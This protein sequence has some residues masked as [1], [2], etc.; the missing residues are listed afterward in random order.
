[1]YR[2][3]KVNAENAT[4]LRLWLEPWLVKMVSQTDGTIDN[5]DNITQ[6][7]HPESILVTLIKLF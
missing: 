6:A 3:L 4:C 5:V 7:L 1:M 2:A